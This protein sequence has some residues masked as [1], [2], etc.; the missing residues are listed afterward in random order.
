M[1][2]PMAI[3]ASTST[4]PFS[5]HH[6]PYPR[7]HKAVNGG[8]SFRAN[9]GDAWKRYTSILAEP[10]TQ[11]LFLPH[12]RCTSFCLA[13]SKKHHTILA[14][15]IPGAFLDK[16]ASQLSKNKLNNVSVSIPT[17]V[18]AYNYS[19][20]YLTFSCGYLTRKEV[21]APESILN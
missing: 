16:S 18:L 13:S 15:F 5:L 12:H 4:S 8:L 14:R 20:H 3:S 10:V 21:H 11:S 17:S 6:N 19:E 7:L 2:I 1:P 9:K